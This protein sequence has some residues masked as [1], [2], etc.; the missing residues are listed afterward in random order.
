MLTLVLMLGL[1]LMLRR[2]P[3]LN[4]E[5]TFGVLN[6]SFPL[7]EVQKVGFNVSVL[8]KLCFIRISVFHVPI[9]KL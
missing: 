8:P 5:V 3:A 6:A 2:K 7:Q 4:A 9:R 1:V